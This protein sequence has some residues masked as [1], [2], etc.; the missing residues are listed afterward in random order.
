MSRDATMSNM[1]HA[2][3]HGW[4]V[5]IWCDITQ[6]NNHLC[7]DH[8]DSMVGLVCENYARCHD[9]ASA[10]GVVGPDTLCHILGLEHLGGIL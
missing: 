4:F 8:S 2:V 7:L 5:D 3:S 6:H 9:S 10:S 1:S